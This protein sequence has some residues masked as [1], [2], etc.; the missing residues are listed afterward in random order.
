MAKHNDNL[1]ITV[2]S[3]SHTAMREAHP[4]QTRNWRAS[5]RSFRRFPVR[6]DL[7]ANAN[8]LT[9]GGTLSPS[10]VSLRSARGLLAVALAALSLIALL[11]VPVASAAPA[12]PWVGLDGGRLGDYLWSVKTG[13]PSQRPCLLIGTTWELG[14]FNFHRSK[15]RACAEA[16]SSLA[17]TEAPVVA[18]GVQPSTGAPVGMTAVGMILAP[19]VRRVVITAADGSRAAVPLHRLSGSQARI[20]S[21]GRFQ[22]AA[23]AVHGWWCAERI[24]TEDASG[25]TLWDSGTDEYRCG[26]SGPQLPALSA[27]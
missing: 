1:D 7:A 15:N 12:G 5:Q 9:R 19:T 25:A 10:R 20:A 26:G 13:Q 27:E 16:D 22:Y 4:T 2:H 21:L 23:F 3:C 14:P 8:A 6:H 18:T 17:A 24:V 11:S